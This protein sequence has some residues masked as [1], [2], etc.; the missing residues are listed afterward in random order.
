VIPLLR[1]ELLKARTTRTALGLALGLGL[2]VGGV[3]AIAAATVDHPPAFAVAQR[4]LTRDAIGSVGFAPLFALL[5][6]LLSSTSEYRHGTISPTL[7]ATPSRVRVVLAKA[8]SS[9]LVGL[10]LAVFALA[11]AIAVAVAVLAAR[12]FEVDGGDIG[13]VVL[14]VLVAATLW[15]ALGA[16]I[17]AIVT[18]QVGVIVGCLAFP[19][20]VE[21]LLVVFT[22][23]AHYLP[24]HALGAFIGLGDDG[25]LISA[26]AGVAVTIGYVALA[27][28]VGALRSRARDVS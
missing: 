16:G 9:A 3:A 28:L 22:P 26:W 15:G 6:G 24:F 4:H 8:I 25:G 18:N 21:P 10:G 19:L 5:F 2:L 1:S 27:N 13:R 17:G 20:I 7:L 11:A 23:K 14:G 12:G